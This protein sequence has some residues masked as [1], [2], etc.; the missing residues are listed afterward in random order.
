M[1]IASASAVEPFL[2]LVNGYHKPGWIYRGVSD[3]SYELLPRIGR[4]EYRK[5]YSVKTERLLLQIFKQ[6]A[7]RLVSPLPTSEL[8]WLAVGQHHGLPTRLLDWSYSPLVALYFAVSIEF[9]TDG[10]VYCRHM[11][12]GNNEFDPFKI[13][14]SRKYYPPHISPRIPAQH[15]VFTVE[16]DPTRPLTI[17]R[18]VKVVIPAV[19]K[20]SIRDR[21]SLL[22][23]HDESMFPDL[24]GSCTHLAWR[25]RNSQGA[26]PI[27]RSAATTRQGSG[28]AT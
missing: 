7:I 11:P 14:T 25:L 21:L 20:S 27:N 12:R 5:H 8:E 9:D 1:I 4:L 3:S 16:P 17:R 10:A 18:I 26:W 24:D 22:G 15:A 13:K 2:E 19:A 23:F 28:R 6:R